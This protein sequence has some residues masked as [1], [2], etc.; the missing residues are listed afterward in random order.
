MLSGGGPKVR[1]GAEVAARPGRLVSTFIRYR[2]SL[3][4]TLADS[5]VLRFDRGRRRD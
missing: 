4:A 5:F 3:A 1:V 2:H